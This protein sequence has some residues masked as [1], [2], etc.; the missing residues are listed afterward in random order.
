[1]GGVDS[2][3]FLVKAL[4]GE[5]ELVVVEAE[6]VE[7]GGVEVADADF[8]FDDV[9]GIIVCF[10]VGDSAFDPTAGHPGREALGV[11]VAAVE[12]FFKGSLPVGG[13]AEFASE[14][15]E[16]VLEHS[17]LFEVLDE[18]GARLIDVVGLAF[19]LFR[20]FAVVIPTAVEEL[21]EA[22]A[23]LGHAAGKEAV[24][25]EGAGF[26]DFGAV[27]FFVEG[28]VL[29]GEVGELGDGGLHAEGHFLLGDG[30]LDF[31]VA[32]FCELLFVEF[33]HEIE[34]LVS[35]L[36]ADALGVRKE[37]NGI[38]GRLEGDALVF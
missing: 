4:E 38:A 12:V 20:E 6:L 5:G 22:D 8:V 1:M 19:D 23:A 17:A 31:R 32:D 33:S 34:H 28:F 18:A 35:G 10:S 25:G 30:G 14:D 11:V 3:E 16:G 29:G 27:D 13:A 24:A 7:D 36:A 21:D 15:D 37:E 26:F 9:V 2:G